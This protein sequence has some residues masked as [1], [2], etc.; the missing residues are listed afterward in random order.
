VDLV[1][2]GVDTTF[3]PI[4][5][6][7][8]CDSNSLCGGWQYQGGSCVLRGTLECSPRLATISSNSAVAGLRGGCD[9]MNSTHVTGI[10]QENVPRC[11][12]PHSRGSYVGDTFIPFNDGESCWYKYFTPDEVHDCTQD[13]W[14]ILN[15]GSNVLSFFTQMVNL[16][17]PGAL[18]RGDGL[19]RPLIG[20]DKT[21][22][23]DIID[24]VFANN[25]ISVDDKN[26][27][28]IL[29]YNL[30][31][32][33]DVDSAINCTN[34]SLAFGDSPDWDDKKLSALNDVFEEAPYQAG[35]IRVTLVV[36]QLWQNTEM[37]LSAVGTNVVWKNAQVI[38][39]GQAMAWYTCNKVGWC[40]QPLLGK[41]ES[42]VEDNYKSDLESIMKVGQRTCATARFN[43]FFSTTAYGNPSHMPRNLV[44]VLKDI[45]DKYEWAYYIDPNEFL[46]QDEIEGT[47][48][49]PGI[50]LTMMQ[51]IWNTACSNNVPTHGIFEMVKTSASCW[52]TCEV[53][54]G[55][56]SC[57]C[58]GRTKG[59]IWQCHNERLCTFE[60]YSPASWEIAAYL[61]A[62]YNEVTQPT[63]EENQIR[64]TL[65]RAFNILSASEERVCLAGGHSYGVLK[66]GACG[67]A[68]IITVLA[69]SETLE[70]GIRQDWWSNHSDVDLVPFGV[71]TTFL[72]ID[73]QFEC[74]SNSLCGGWQYQGGSCVL[75]G[76]LECSPRLATISSNSAV[77]GLRGGC[78]D[79]NSTHVTGIQQENVPRCTA[80]H[81][82]GSY[83]GDTFIPFNDGESC[84]YKYF[85]PDEVHDC[86]QDRWIILNGGSNVLSFFT[87]MVNL[88]APGAL[89]RGDGLNRPLIGFDKTY[90]YD[91]IDLVFANN[92]ISVDDKNSDG[93]LHYNLKRFCDVDSAINCTNKSLAFGDSPDWDDKKLSALN[94][95]FEE[96]PYQA[97]A[98]RV[99]LVVGQLWQNT[100]MVLSAVGTNVVWKN[101]QVIFVGQAMAWYTCNKVGWCNQ[102]LLGK[103]ESEVE[104]NYK[105]DL[106]SIMKVGQRT[107][108]TARFNCFFSTTAY[109]N[110]SHMPRNLVTVLKDITDKYEWAYYIDPNEFLVQDEI[111]GT[112]VSPGIFLTMMQMIWNTACSNNVPT[113]GI[114]EM[115]KTSA[116][117][118]KTCEVM[119]GGDSCLCP[120]RTKGKI[121]QCHNERLCT[122]ESYSPPSWEIKVLNDDVTH[123]TPCFHVD[124]ITSFN[125]KKDVTQCNRIWCGTVAAGWGV[126]VGVFAIGVMAFAISSW[127]LKRKSIELQL[128]YPEKNSDCSSTNSDT[129]F[130]I[131]SNSSTEVK[132][133]NK[134][135]FEEYQFSRDNQNSEEVQ[136]VHKKK[137]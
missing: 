61:E 79:M 22:K 69:D 38:F 91:I 83:V 116:S 2:F 14:I 26:S 41:T 122:F 36:G 65:A 24:L 105:S 128:V 20:F 12:A 76:T 42:E 102:P 70:L 93:I 136:S 135:T 53:M 68:V 45:T 74:D 39:V 121:W 29:H 131:Y 17:A 100:E 19:N 82:R 114:F 130:D 111:E 32:F 119:E 103:T 88:F 49:S 109:G 48:V 80:P 34:K 133:K 10:Q 16:F 11:T 56:D 8:E 123:V 50:F 52:K 87:Q 115:V 31:R 62:S 9:D 54:E 30:K 44:T 97:G 13:R 120:G 92:D 112:H 104:D 37:V 129:S 132:V 7:F 90:K 106:E 113:H 118:W 64:Q 124:S 27:D 43:C 134:T 6:Q 78:D 71:D 85:T 99:T 84:W 46:V 77:A 3:L 98:I 81:S 23:Y 51:M 40:N 59:K 89:S 67:D 126:S 72:P 4:D 25:D 35:A 28:G 21:Y 107:C 127:M 125:L 33:C 137:N 117:C 108:A 15:G 60:S 95:V 5:C 96:A 63:K 58:P 57:L 18:S 73:C 66:D 110:P 47:H 101:A 86:T 55:G 1:P 75:R 94:D